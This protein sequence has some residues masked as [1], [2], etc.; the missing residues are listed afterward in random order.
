VDLATLYNTSNLTIQWTHVGVPVSNP[1]AVTDSGNYRIIVINAQG[2]SDTANIRINFHSVPQL[3]A[4]LAVG[5][6]PGTSLN[7]NPLFTTTGLASSWSTNANVVANPASVNLPGIY[8][9]VVTNGNGCK[10]TAQVQLVSSPQTSFG[11]RSTT[12]SMCGQHR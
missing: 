9:L 11:S 7:L 12:G 2:C 4:D 10:D 5:I 6:C 8:Q 1:S 3:G